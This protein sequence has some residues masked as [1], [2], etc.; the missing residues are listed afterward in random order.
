M[1]ILLKVNAN[2]QLVWGI[3][4][5][6]RSF[7]LAFTHLFIYL[8]QYLLDECLLSIKYCA[9]PQVYSDKIGIELNKLM[10]GLRLNTLSFSWLVETLH[11]L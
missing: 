2:K 7:L 5:L 3:C 10:R 1:L 9:G 4:F 11:L 8:V 6:I